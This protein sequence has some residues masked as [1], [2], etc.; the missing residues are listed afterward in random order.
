MF[1]SAIVL[2]L[3]P[4][5]LTV[6]AERKP[7]RPASVAAAA[8]G[9]TIAGAALAGAY[10]S[11]D[12]MNASQPPI[13]IGTS[14]IP[15]AGLYLGEEPPEATTPGGIYSNL[16]SG[17]GNAAGASLLFLVPTFG[18]VL[19]GDEDAGNGATYGTVG[20]VLVGT[21]ASVALGNYLPQWGRVVVGALVTGSFATLGYHL[22]DR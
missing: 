3:V 12:T 8:V 7:S 14:L 21:A 1:R 10:A 22:G 18:T 13:A 6:S 5:C 20:G 16:L 9:V 17:M 4:G 15:M 11:S 19:S 2:C